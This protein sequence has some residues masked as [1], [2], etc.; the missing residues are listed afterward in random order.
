MN[1]FWDPVQPGRILFMRM[2]QCCLSLSLLSAAVYSVS[3][4]KRFLCVQGVDIGGSHCVPFCSR[5]SGLRPLANVIFCIVMRTVRPAG[6]H[7]Q[8]SAGEL[9]VNSI[10]SGDRWLLMAFWYRRK[11]LFPFLST[12]IK[13]SF[14][15]PSLACSNSERRGMSAFEMLS[16]ASRTLQNIRYLYNYKTRYF[17]LFS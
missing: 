16:W 8:A 9:V 10:T 2:G 15:T 5:L 1:V 13:C 11:W 6:R 4:K 3:A 17:L 12:I 14:C 7:R